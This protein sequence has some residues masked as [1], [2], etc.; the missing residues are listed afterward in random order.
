M[1]I[2]LISGLF[3]AAIFFSLIGV[4]YF[5]WREARQTQV[6]IEWSTA[7]E[8]ETVGFNIYR[9]ET[10]TEPGV[11]VNTELIPASEDSQTGGDYKYTDKNVEP[12]KMY[13]YF[14]EDVSSDGTTNING[15]VTIK[16]QTSV[17]TIWI[18]LIALATLIMLGM[19]VIASP[20]RKGNQK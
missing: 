12:G 1:K 20:H 10:P 16:A 5:A 17:K 4:G 14:L 3:L 13:Y 11:Q 2:R 6:V 19:I 7:S 9:S 8:F 15:P 18:L